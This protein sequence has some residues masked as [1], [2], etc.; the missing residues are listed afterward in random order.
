MKMGNMARV[1]LALMTVFCLAWGTGAEA[2]DQKFGWVDSQRLLDETESGKKI[3]S[4]VEAFVSS[5][6]T[7]ID[8]EA[9]EIE[10]LKD[11]LDKQM[12]LL[13]DEA[14][15]EKQLE[16]QKRYLDYQ[17]KVE[18][19]A[20]ELEK[21][22]LE[23]LVEFNEVVEAAL[24]K[25]AAAGGYVMIFDFNSGGALLYGDDSLDLTE[26]IKA[27]IDAAQP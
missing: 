16:F 17:K 11:K 6:Q 1:S 22:K 8:V 14:R 20:G 26:K 25:V 15:R 13:S 23:L 18:E 10:T 2:A 19:L 21:K 27:E 4:R 24:D 12:P 7:V 9:K 3:K 5:R